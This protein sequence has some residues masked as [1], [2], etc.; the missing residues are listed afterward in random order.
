[1]NQSFLKGSFYIRTRKCGWYLWHQS[2]NSG[3]RNQKTVPRIA[4]Q[5]L[6]FCR[7]FSTEQAKFQC[8]QLNKERSLLNNQKRLAGQ[9]LTDFL[10]VNEVLFPTSEVGE[11]EALLKEENFGN[12]NYLKKL[13]SH[14]CFVQRLCVELKIQ[15]SEYKANA[16]RIYKYLIAKKVSVSYA[17]RLLEVLNRWG[18]FKCKRAGNFFEEVKIPKGRERSAIAAAQLTKKGTK[19]ELG[20]RSESLP[21]TLNLLVKIQDS[22]PLVQYNWLYLSVWLGLRPWEIDSLH[23]I[24]TYRIDYNE[25]LK[26]KVLSV[27]QS[28]LMSLNEK[29]RWKSIPIVFKEQVRCIEI[30]ESGLFQR[31]LNK[32]VHKYVGAAITTYGGRKGFVDLMLGKG[33]NLENISIWMGHKNIATTWRSYKYKNEVGFTSTQETNN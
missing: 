27:Y 3:K 11:F 18:K 33:Q 28:K 19:T 30:I 29:E 7:T 13:R 8:S 25:R 9:R 2:Y 10:S 24:R 32:T 17:S 22:L 6:G 15:P 5:S 16:K 21:L 20:V 1:M 12:E 14:F 4:M 23:I 26:I 31:P